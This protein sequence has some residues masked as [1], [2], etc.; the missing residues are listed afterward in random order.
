MPVTG[1]GAW[2]RQPTTHTLYRNERAGTEKKPIGVEGDGRVLFRIALAVRGREV[3]R[4]EKGAGAGAW[5]GAMRP[6]KPLGQ[7]LS[8]CSQGGAA[9]TRGLRQDCTP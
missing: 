6:H 3:T 7:R 5:R 4:E 8:V 1:A 9:H 2:G